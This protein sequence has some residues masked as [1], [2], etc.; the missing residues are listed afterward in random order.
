MPNIVTSAQRG[1][2][3]SFRGALN[4][5]AFYE[6]F[7]TDF[8][9]TAPAAP[10]LAY[11]AGAGSLAES[12]AAVKITWITKNGESLPSAEATA[13]I[14]AA[15]GAVTVTQP[16][17]PTNGATVIG[18]RVY[19]GNGSGSEALNAASN[20]TTQAQSSFT[21][22]NGSGGTTTITGFPIA[23]TA[24]QVLIYGA[25]AAV[26]VVDRSGIQN[27]LPS[28]SANDSFDYVLVVGNQG[29]LW[30]QQSAVDYI[31]PDGTSETVGVSIGGVDVINPLY[32]G[33]STDVNA[34]VTPASYCVLNGY[35][36]QCTTSGETAATFIGAGAFNQS[37]GAT[38]TDGSVVWTSLGKASII[39][40]R[41]LN[42]T[43]SAA[44]P[45]AQ[46]YDFFAL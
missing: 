32:P 28:V 34:G 8:G 12:T 15:T 37:R 31:R 27:A 16:T 18:W 25:G 9:A 38:T 3:S 19:S 41:F 5:K 4:P 29:S 2:N 30:R 10:S 42:S 43:G 7:G 1:Y 22:S 40:I 20:S 6:V 26:P 45:A 46:E 39:R 17:V 33:T 35:L 11:N 21:V 24:V 44:V 13:S 14:A 23:T 36:Y